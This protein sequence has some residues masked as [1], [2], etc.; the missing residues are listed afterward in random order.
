MGIVS[1]LETPMNPSKLL[2]PL[3]LAAVAAL[4]AS[5]AAAQSAMFVHVVTAASIP[6]GASYATALHH[7]L[8]DGNAFVR[9]FVSQLLNP[10]GPSGFVNSHPVNVDFTDLGAPLGVRW[11]IM[12][13]DVAAMPIGAAFNVWVTRPYT[14]PGAG[15]DTFAHFTNATNINGNT[16]LLDHPDLN[17]FPGRTPIVTPL[18]NAPH[19]EVGVWY[20]ELNGKWTI[21]NEDLGTFSN[22]AG[23]FVCTKPPC[24]TGFPASA[25]SDTTF[26]SCTA[27]NVAGN[28]CYLPPLHQRQAI[29]LFNRVWDGVYL[30]RALGVWWSS[31]GWAV[32]TEDGSA[33]PVGVGL[34]VSRGMGIF[35]SGF[36]TGT[37]LGWQPAP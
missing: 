32:F 9:V 19:K 10:T 30:D 2:V 11:I 16:T 17:G 31:I 3:A 25:F 4:G 6:V 7:P 33:M 21:Y 13:R 18:Y 34:R 23:F 15:A 37:T 1:R 24:D 29:L 8:L 14:L 27:G 20:D 35:E 22:N 5:P 28:S 12:N 26:F 36:E